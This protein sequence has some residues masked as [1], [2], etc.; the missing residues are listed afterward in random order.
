M[1]PNAEFMIHCGSDG[2]DGDSR[3]FEATARW[4][5]KLNARMIDIYAMRCSRGPFFRRKKMTREKVRQFLRDGLNEKR[6]WYM[7]AIEAVDYGFMDGIYGTT[8]FR[9]IEEITR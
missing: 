6:E 3:S 1:M 8:G 9:N 4:S 7:T 5:E 2:F